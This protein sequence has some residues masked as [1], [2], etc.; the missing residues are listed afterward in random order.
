MGKSQKRDRNATPPAPP[1]LGRRL[2]FLAAIVLAVAIVTGMAFWWSRRQQADTPP[3][4]A[5]VAAATAA[6]QPVPAVAANPGFEKLKGR[7]LRPDGG[8]VI[9]IRS[10][11]PGGRLDAGYFNPRSIHVATAQASQEGGTTKVFLELR[12]ANYPGSNYTLTYDPGSDRLTGIYFQAAVGQS[13]DVTFSR[14]TP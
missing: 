5:P 4:N 8:Y 10:V 9:E 3:G 2:S 11:S 14:L 1:A 7:W 12:D 13:F 6:S